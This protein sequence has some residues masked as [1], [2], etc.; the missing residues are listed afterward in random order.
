MKKIKT[1]LLIG[2][3]CLGLTNV[4]VANASFFGKQT[5]AEIQ[6][7]QDNIKKADKDI[8]AKLYKVQPE[9]KD[10]ISKSSG[11][12]TFS[13]F[14]MKIFLAGGGTGKGIVTPKNGKPIYMDM[15][16]IQAGLGIGIKQFQVV[17]VFE[18]QKAL[19]SFINQGWEFGGQA[20][21]AAKYG[22]NGG[23]YQGAVN[24]ADGIWMYQLT[25]N[26]LAAEVTLKGTK[27]YKD[28]TLN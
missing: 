3:F 9:A 24:V 5:P 18:N 16:E 2:A 17:F 7:S 28:S 1:S 22:E 12:A 14:G 21:A 19:D 15:A 11:Y 25:E 10:L 6:K 8:L 27:Y 13:N 4:G 23:A 26:G 20:T